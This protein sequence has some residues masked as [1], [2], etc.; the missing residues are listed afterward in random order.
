MEGTHFAAGPWFTVQ[1]SGSGW[2]QLGTIEL[3]DGATTEIV[4]VE[5]RVDF[6]KDS[7]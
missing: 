4:N 3:G 1:E 7:L 5:F 2:N 6:E